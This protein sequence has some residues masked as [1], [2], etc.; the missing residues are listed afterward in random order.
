ME[1]MQFTDVAFSLRKTHGG[2]DSLRQDPTGLRVGRYDKGVCVEEAGSETASGRSLGAG[3]GHRS[4]L[5]GGLDRSQLGPTRRQ[6]AL[7]VH[8]A[9]L[10]EFRVRRGGAQCCTPLRRGLPLL[11]LREF[12]CWPCHEPGRVRQAV[13]PGGT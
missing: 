9:R 10:A 12:E 6:D 2:V 7:R 13:H 1:K 5:E 8:A 11:T 4:V 3:T